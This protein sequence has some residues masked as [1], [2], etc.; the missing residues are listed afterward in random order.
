M[1]TPTRTETLGLGLTLSAKRVLQSA[2]TQHGARSVSSYSRAPLRAQK[3]RCPII[4]VSASMPPM[5]RVPEG[6]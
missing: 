2:A 6:T 5:V 3:R 4:G 1:P